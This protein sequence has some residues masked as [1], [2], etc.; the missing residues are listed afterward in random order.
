MHQKDRGAGYDQLLLAQSPDHVAGQPSL[1]SSLQ[2]QNE[3]PQQKT[4]ATALQ[5]S[6]QL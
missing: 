1:P 2:S 5:A 4:R 6:Q 3:S